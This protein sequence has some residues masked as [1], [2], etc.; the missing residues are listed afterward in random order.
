MQGA[1]AVDRLDAVAAAQS[2]PLG[3]TVPSDDGDQ[4]HVLGGQVGF[5]KTQFHGEQR[6]LVDGSRP[7]DRVQE[8]GGGEDNRQCGAK[9]DQQPR[10]ET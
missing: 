5:V 8:R 2:G 10:V 3:W 6:R 1:V 9:R 7:D 4:A